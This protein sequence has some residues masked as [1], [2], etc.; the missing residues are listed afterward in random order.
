[1]MTLLVQRISLYILPLLSGVVLTLSFPRFDLYP[2][3]WIALVPLFCFLWNRNSRE[4]FIGGFVFGLVSFFGTLSWISHSINHYGGFSLVSSLAIV[5]LLCAYLSLYPAVFSLIYASVI[6]RTKLPS[7][8]LAPV[9]WVVL[10]YV[11]TYA[12]SGFPWASIGY[13]QYR[14]LP[15]IQISDITG[16]YGVSFLVVAFNGAATDVFLLKK[17][18]Q[19]MPL[20]PLSYTAAGFAVFGAMILFSL[21]YG[22]WRLSQERQGAAVAISV[23]QGNIEQDRKWVPAYQQE[24]MN[25]YTGLT[26]KAA[27]DRPSLIVWPETAVPF[28]F[29]HDIEHSSRLSAVQRDIGIPLLFGA[30]RVKEQAGGTLR[31]SNSAVLLDHEGKTVALY[32][33]I[34]LVPFGEYV[35]LKQLLFFMEKLVAGT[36]D[37]V[38][39]DRTFRMMT[40]F[41]SFGTLIC[42]EIAFPGMVRKFYAD[43][44]DA[45]VTI[46]NDAWFGRTSG[47]YQHFSMGVFRAVENRKPLIRAANTGI[48]GFIDSNGRILRMS[49]L[50]RREVVSAS[51]QTDSTRTAYSAYGDLFVYVCIVAAIMVL[52]NLKTWR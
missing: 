33:K 6:R 47:P 27:L 9:F 42:Y 5:L 16:V 40:P 19:S 25:I 26:Q 41:G 34:H 44:G 23:V 1:M 21:G 49:S 35:P 32:D 36:G 45:I 22:G 12:F 18:M 8:L 52:M 7:V 39:G 24:V 43:G 48:S 17:R 50:F 31:L 28:Y 20:F 51:L 37:F 2:L 10:E 38:P 15:L 46:T 11:R 30:V 13:S 3:A 29:G 14:F 4:A